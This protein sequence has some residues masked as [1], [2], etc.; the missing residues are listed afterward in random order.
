M[1]ELSANHKRALSSTLFLME[2]MVEEIASTLSKTDDF[3]MQKTVH[4]LDTEKKASL[5]KTLDLIRAEIKT[6]AEK[7]ELSPQQLVESHFI[8]ARK[9][10]IW[11]MLHN[12]KAKQLNAFG[13]FPTELKAEFDADLNNLLNLIDKL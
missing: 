6:M 11:E 8:N 12:T 4:D 10:K 1:P 13:K 5:G 9:S 7:Y 2:K 3:T